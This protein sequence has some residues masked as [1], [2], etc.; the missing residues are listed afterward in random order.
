MEMKE[1]HKEPCPSLCG[2]L[3]ITLPKQGGDGHREIVGNQYEK[4]IVNL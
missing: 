3:V 2:S 4:S 1:L